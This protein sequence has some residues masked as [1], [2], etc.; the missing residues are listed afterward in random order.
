MLIK[1]NLIYVSYF[2]WK[3]L[4]LLYAAVS[5]SDCL[6]IPAVCHKEAIN[7]SIKFNK[8]NFANY[9]SKSTPA[10]QHF[11]FSFLFCAA[12]TYREQAG[13]QATCYTQST[14]TLHRN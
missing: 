13:R 6:S 8:N 1:S 12:E 10:E 3:I 11:A 7:N 9:C 5:Q 2:C 14:E 4:V